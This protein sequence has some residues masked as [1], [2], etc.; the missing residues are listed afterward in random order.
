MV[1][2]YA[3]LHVLPSADA[4]VIKAAFRVLARRYHPDCCTGSKEAAHRRMQEINAAYEVLSDEQKRAAYDRERGQAKSE[5][6]FDGAGDETDVLFEQDWQVACKYCPDAK[7]CFDY[8]SRF[9]TKLAFSYASYLIDTKKFQTCREIAQKFHNEFA[10]NY[11]G[12][13]L[14]IQRFAS[15]LLLCGEKEAAKAINQ[16]V[17][18]LG[19]SLSVD[20]LTQKVFSEHP[21]SKMRVTFLRA[22]YA[23]NDTYSAMEFLKL[24]GLNYAK[25]FWGDSLKINYMNNELKIG[26]LECADWVKENFGGT[27]DFRCVWQGPEVWNGGFPLFT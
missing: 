1:D 24:M 26:C 20:Q 10:S 12:G 27:E 2:Y 22:I 23:V 9:S 5:A 7:V 11:F 25:T 3:I 21:K 18:V 8:L 16:A 14:L 13:N 15:Q 4:D 6:E 19:K 17:R